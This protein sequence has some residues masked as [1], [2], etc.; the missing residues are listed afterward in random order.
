MSS[1]VSHE[2]RH[3]VELA[4]CPPFKDVT[5]YNDVSSVVASFYSERTV[6]P[7]SQPPP[8]SDH[9]KRIIKSLYDQTG[10]YKNI[11]WTLNPSHLMAF[12]TKIVYEAYPKSQAEIDAMA[13][14]LHIGKVIYDP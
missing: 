2:P 8:A 1:E 10:I 12:E 7:A 6:G 4:S 3:K 14:R 13:A 9:V 5:R 11:G